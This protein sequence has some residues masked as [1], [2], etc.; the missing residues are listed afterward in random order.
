MTTEKSEIAQALPEKRAELA[1]RL[2]PLIAQ[3]SE[4][5]R[6]VEAIERREMLTDERVIK[7]IGKVGRWMGIQRA[8]IHL[9]H[10]KTKL[11]TVCASLEHGV[12]YGVS[13][14]GEEK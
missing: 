1:A 12:P 11:T 5:C 10:A 14:E 9:W 4:V 13:P 2:K 7:P 8:G 3:I 6:E